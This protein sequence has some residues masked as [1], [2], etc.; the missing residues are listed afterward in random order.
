MTKTLSTG[1]L[2]VQSNLEVKRIGSVEK[3]GMRELVKVSGECV[4]ELV[5]VLII[6]VRQPPV[7]EM[8]LELSRR[9]F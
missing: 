8:T 6:L 3:A 2:A 7:A 1:T 9:S 5:I 4:S